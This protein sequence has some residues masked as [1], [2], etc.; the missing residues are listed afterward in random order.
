[1]GPP[2][3]RIMAVLEEWAVMVEGRVSPATVE[4]PIRVGAAT[5]DATRRI[6]LTARRNK[7]M[8]R[9]QMSLATTSACNRLLAA[10]ISGVAPP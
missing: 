2:K 7:V 9:L 5:I 4:A 8:L 6:P 10:T 1:M 3:H